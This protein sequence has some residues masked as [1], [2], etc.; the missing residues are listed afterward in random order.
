MP[1]QAGCG[2]LT[3]HIPYNSKTLD[4]LSPQISLDVAMHNWLHVHIDGKL[5]QQNWKEAKRS[6]HV[7]LTVVGSTRFSWKGKK[8]WKALPWDVTHLCY[9]LKD[10]SHGSE[11]SGGR[12]S[13]ATG[14]RRL[15][16]V[17]DTVW[18][19]WKQWLGWGWGLNNHTEWTL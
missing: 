8:P 5:S 18:R 13:V 3:S 19:V 16:Q 6:S 15:V 4:C 17:R 14:Y 7:S 10:S 11:G 2:L 12:K 1:Q 9:S